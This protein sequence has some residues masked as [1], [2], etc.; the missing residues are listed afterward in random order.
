VNVAFVLH[1]HLPWVRRNGTYPVGEEWLFQALA[2]SYLPLLA[3]LERLA[4][5]GHREV[6][7]SQAAV[8]GG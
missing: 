3:V 8:G 5:A 1:T 6:G 2:D 4:D 7:P